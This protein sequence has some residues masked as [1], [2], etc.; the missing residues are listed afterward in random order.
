MSIYIII[1]ELQNATQYT[2][3]ES[4]KKRTKRNI[5]YKYIIYI[6][7]IYININNI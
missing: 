1:I 3:E 6:I 2:T 4:A 7:I 5:I